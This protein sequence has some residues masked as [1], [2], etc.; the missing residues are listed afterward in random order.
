M[1]SRSGFTIVEL[2]I[3]IV[4]IAILAA[5]TIVAYNG[6]Q[7]RAK[8]SLVR[9]GLAQKAR[10]LELDKVE[11]GEY[12]P[13]LADIKLSTDGE[14]SVSFEYSREA[15]GSDSTFCLTGVLDKISMHVQ[16]GNKQVAEAACP[17]HNDPNM[18]PPEISYQGYQKFNKPGATTP[19]EDSYTIDF[20]LKPTDLV[21][22]VYDAY[23][24]THIR[25][26]SAG[27]VDFERVYRKSMG[28][29]GYQQIL[30]YKATGLSGPQTLVTG[31]C[32]G[33]YN[34]SACYDASSVRGEYVVYVIRGKSN[35]SISYTDTSFGMQT[36]G[37][38]LAPEAQSVSANDVAI[39]AH[40][41]YG[42]YLPTFV[43]NSSPGLDWTVDKVKAIGAA[44]PGT[45]H[46]A[47][48]VSRALSGASGT[49]APALNMPS[50]GSVY[51]GATLFVIK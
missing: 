34:Q 23:F 4:V 25:E 8:T 31:S 1:K 27:G 29:S 51:A 19:V 14:S 2:L 45:S 50:D 32:Y 12:A 36:R 33:G 11:R 30:A 20:D 18:P 21:F 37:S 41:Y 9:E 38:T 17:G 42:N 24:Y 47:I 39:F 10:Q 40:V 28:A 22:V 5:V 48:N 43:D 44:S 49:V 46:D 26:V 16:S 35:P 15:T 7:H 13:T 3:V 6:L